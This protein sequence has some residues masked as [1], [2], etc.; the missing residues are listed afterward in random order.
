M[1]SILERRVEKWKPANIDELE[2]FIHE[3]WQKVNTSTVNN[4]IGLME[5]RYLVIIDSSDE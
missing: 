1:W 4:I 2:I 3:E 5:T